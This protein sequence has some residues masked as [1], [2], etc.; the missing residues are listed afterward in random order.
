MRFIAVL[1]FFVSLGP[2]RA[3]SGNFFDEPL[4]E[5]TKAVVY[6]ARLHAGWLVE[7]YRIQIDNQESY[8]RFADSRGNRYWVG[9]DV[10]IVQINEPLK[11]FIDKYRK[12]YS[13]G[14]VE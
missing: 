2:L 9:S 4:P 7:Y 13:I 3:T 12:T 8:L 1:I 11:E 14:D 6:D 10:T 5:I